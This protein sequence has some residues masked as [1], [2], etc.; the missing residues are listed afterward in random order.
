MD[1]STWSGASKAAGGLLWAGALPCRPVRLEGRGEAGNWVDSLSW[2]R[3]E[4]REWIR[5]RLRPRGIHSSRGRS[6]RSGP[7]HRWRSP[8][9]AYWQTRDGGQGLDPDFARYD[10][11]DLQMPPERRFDGN[12]QDV[13]RNRRLRPGR[14]DACGRRSRAGSTAPSGRRPALG[15]ESRRLRPAA[16]AS[17]LPRTRTIRSAPGSCRRTRRAADAGR[18]SVGGERN[19]RRRAD[20]PAA[21]LWTG[22]RATPTTSCTGMRW[23]A[24]TMAATWRWAR[25]PAGLWF[26]EDEGAHWHCLSRDLPPIAAVRFV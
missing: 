5:R 22:H 15:A 3:P 14:P 9:A 25:P 11:R 17:P 12:I 24:R 2:Q 13:H 10:G 4:R 7:P 19:A 1:P 18:W 16:S 21:H 6:A 8:A 26:S 20:L 23:P